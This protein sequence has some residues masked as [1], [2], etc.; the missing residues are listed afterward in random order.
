MKEI[1]AEKVIILPNNKKIVMVAK[2][3]VELLVIEVAV[4]PTKT[5]P[6]GLAAV[7]AF[8]PGFC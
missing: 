3:A 6:Q 2:K 8:N 1:G 5:I 4:V 7:L